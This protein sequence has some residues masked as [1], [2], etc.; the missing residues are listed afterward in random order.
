MRKDLNYLTHC[1][2]KEFFASD[3]E[4]EREKEA[5]GSKLVYIYIYIDIRETNSSSTLHTNGASRFA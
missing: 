4:R 5:R 1:S 2:K 3:P